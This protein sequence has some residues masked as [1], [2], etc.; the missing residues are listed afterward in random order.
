MPAM[1]MPLPM[2]G[3]EIVAMIHPLDMT[4]KC[5]VKNNLTEA[6]S[7]QLQK[8]ICIWAFIGKVASNI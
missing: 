2:P 1:S 6:A 4:A 8:S 3:L 5:S 7:S